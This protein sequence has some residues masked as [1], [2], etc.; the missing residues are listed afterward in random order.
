[1][2]MNQYIVYKFE[3]LEKV[4]NDD[5]DTDVNT[6]NFFK[7]FTEEKITNLN[8][9]KENTQIL[10]TNE[11]DQ[12]VT[13]TKII[14]SLNKLNNSN[15]KKIYSQIKE[16]VFSTDEELMMLVKHCLTKIKEESEIMKPEFGNLCKELT[17]LYFKDKNNEKIH[18]PVLMLNSV[19]EQYSSAM[20][21][22]SEKWDKDNAKKTMILVGT[23]INSKVIESDI[24]TN[25]VKD[26][27]NRV[28][29]FDESIADKNISEVE[30]SIELLSTLIALI[31]D[32]EAKEKFAQINDFL[33]SELKKHEENKASKNKISIRSKLFYRLIVETL[34]EK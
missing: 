11:I 25:I 23:L 14:Q 10:L 20:T 4:I 8:R 33:K 24:I 22:D 31:S 12:D 15:M 13:R 3:E 17:S 29:F 34:D 2:T 28:S 6:V 18:L 26:F 1:M 32:H 21:F 16:I 30:D 19:F 7:T 5:K 9:Q 27:K